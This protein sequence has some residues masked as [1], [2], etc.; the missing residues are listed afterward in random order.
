MDVHQTQAN[1]TEEE[2]I[3]KYRAALQAAPFEN[4]RF[5]RF[6]AA[7]ARA[8]CTAVA[9]AGRIMDTLNPTQPLRPEAT[10]QPGV[11]A[12]RKFQTSPR[13]QSLAL[14]KDEGVTK[15]AS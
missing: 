7:L 1:S 11:A 6:R 8:R 4:S 5:A 3:A 12:I 10:V 15:R 2:W 14:A 13:K 9:S